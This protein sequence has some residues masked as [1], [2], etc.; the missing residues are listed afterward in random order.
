MK[1]GWTKERPTVFIEGERDRIDMQSSKIKLT[2][3]IPKLSNG[4]MPWLN[5]YG[6]L[7]YGRFRPELYDPRAHALRSLSNRILSHASMLD[8]EGDWLELAKEDYKRFYSIK[9]TA[10]Y[11]YMSR[12]ALNE[13]WRWPS[14][15]NTYS[16][17]NETDGIHWENGNS[18]C[19]ANAVTKKEPWQHQWLLFWQEKNKEHINPLCDGGQL[20]ETDEQL[21]KIL[22]LDHE[23]AFHQP[24]RCELGVGLEGNKVDFKWMHDGTEQV[25]VDTTDPVKQIWRNYINWQ[26]KQ[27]GRPRIRIFAAKPKLI[28]DPWKIWDTEINLLEN[29]DDSLDL[30]CYREHNN[31]TT[32]IEH[33]LWYRGDDLLDLG[34]FQFWLDLKH[35]VYKDRDRRFILYR[36]DENYVDREI[37]VA[38]P[39][40][41]SAY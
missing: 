34:D 3:S 26:R 22:N 21:H 5:D 27:P 10:F 40:Q 7:Y 11:M 19:C 29:L 4:I 33:T 14:F 36:A 16:T 23:F 30:I 6:N 37:A 39:Q 31:K 41:S 25:Q 20:I 18:R 8:Y 35:S 32:D 28:I 13:V 38:Y 9:S 15:A 17:E 1:N 2:L 24:V 12:K